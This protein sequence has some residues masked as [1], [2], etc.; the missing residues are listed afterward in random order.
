M[1]EGDVDKP[2]HFF[3]LLP[4]YLPCTL[5][6]AMENQIIV[7]Y[8]GEC[9]FC[10]SSIK[11]IEQRID[12]DSIPFQKADLTKY[13]LTYQ[14]CSKSVQVISNG[15]VLAGAPAIAFL[16][17]KRCNHFLSLLITTSGPFGRLGY[18]WVSTHRSSIVIKIAHRLLEQSNLRHKKK[19]KS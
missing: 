13:G 5:N 17:K 9:A 2:F 6:L 16:L 10:E 12:V 14:E 8:D 18:K 7:I 19:P 4:F 11:W 3:T 1:I 15:T